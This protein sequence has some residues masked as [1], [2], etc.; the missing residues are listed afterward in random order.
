ALPNDPRRVAGDDRIG[1]DI[2]SH[3]GTGCDHR[4][5]T[6]GAARK[7]DRTMPDPDVMPEINHVRAAPRAKVLFVP[8]AREVGACAISE[9]R[10]SRST[11]RMVARID[12]CHGRDRAE[13]TEGRVSNL[14]VVDDV[15]VIA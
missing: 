11:H 6:D 4:A 12:S 10:L 5:G 13:F 8:L 3:H 15:G 1:I 14:A 7:D 9:M 2:F